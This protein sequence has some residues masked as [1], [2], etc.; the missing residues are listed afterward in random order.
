MIVYHVNYQLVINEIWKRTVL[1][2]V[3]R[4][5]LRYQHGS[6]MEPEV[7]KNYSE[8]K[9]NKV[10]DT[11]VMLDVI[12]INGR[13]IILEVRIPEEMPTPRIWSFSTI[14]ACCSKGLIT[15]TIHKSSYLYL[16]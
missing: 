7:K 11:G 12:I 3:E 10:V 8:I 1:Y 13:G 2:I 9:G 14:M 16:I 5:Y 4:A 6:K 15:M